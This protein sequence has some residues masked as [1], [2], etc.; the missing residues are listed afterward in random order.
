MDTFNRP[1]GLT[2]YMRSGTF[3]TLL[4]ILVI[5]TIAASSGFAIWNGH[6]SA[7]E[8]RKRNMAR[9][10][11]VLA[12]QTSR[13]VQVIDVVMQGLQSRIVNMNLETPDEFRRK[14]DA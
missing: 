2:R 7:L 1:G 12:E 4:C 14:L 8:N 5:A 11:M 9:I 6:R 3:L 10:G 13:H